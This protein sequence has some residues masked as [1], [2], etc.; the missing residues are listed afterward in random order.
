[1]PEPDLPGWSD[2]ARALLPLLG[3][4]GDDD[5]LMAAEL[6]RHLGEF[7]AALRILDSVASE[8]FSPIVA[9]MRAAAEQ[10]SLQVVPLPETD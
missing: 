4:E 3:S 5:R 9:I 7:D 1:L 10:E 6:H 2:N 8:Q